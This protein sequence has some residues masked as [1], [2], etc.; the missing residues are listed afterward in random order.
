MVGL[1]KS[2]QHGFQAG[3]LGVS[4]SKRRCI[5]RLG[6][7]LASFTSKTRYRAFVSFAEVVENMERERGLEPPASSFGNMSVDCK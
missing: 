7:V 6:P 3:V 1:A 5:N 4:L 2:C